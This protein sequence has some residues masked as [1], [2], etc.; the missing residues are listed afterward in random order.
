MH[1][2]QRTLKIYRYLLSPYQGLFPWG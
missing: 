1:F 2:A